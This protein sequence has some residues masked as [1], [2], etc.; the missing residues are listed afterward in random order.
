MLQDIGVDCHEADHSTAFALR[1]KPGIDAACGCVQRS[2]LTLD[3]GAFVVGRPI[4]STVRTSGGLIQIT[5]PPRLS[6][7]CITLL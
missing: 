2:T 5:I 1:G 6:A 7:F 3:A 4:R